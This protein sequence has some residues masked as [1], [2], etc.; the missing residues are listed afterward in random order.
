MNFI[1]NNSIIIYRLSNI[2][3]E[4]RNEQGA[5]SLNK[6]MDFSALLV[7]FVIRSENDVQGHPILLS[8]DIAEDEEILRELKQWQ[9]PVN[10]MLEGH[11]GYS[12]VF[13][14]GDRSSCRLKE[15]NMGNFA[16][17]SMVKFQHVR[18]NFFWSEIVYSNSK[19]PS[20]F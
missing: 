10:E 14:D 9:K 17:D 5:I 12:A 1:S 6:T 7:R 3:F 15:C 18:A 4:K 20:G 11:V 16:T 8:D 2:D 19:M 13:L